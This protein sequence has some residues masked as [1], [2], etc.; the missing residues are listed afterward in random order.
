MCNKKILLGK[1]KCNSE[2]IQSRSLFQLW[3]KMVLYFVFPNTNKK[4]KKN[5]NIFKTRFIMKKNGE[6]LGFGDSQYYQ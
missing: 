4:I 6:V 5:K 2:K 3:K 1:M